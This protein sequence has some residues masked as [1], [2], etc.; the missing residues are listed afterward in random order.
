M[1]TS[2]LG[3]GKQVTVEFKREIFFYFQLNVWWNELLPEQKVVASIVAINIGVFLLWRVVPLQRI[4]LTYF[5][6]SPISGIHSKCFKQ[7][8]V[9]MNCWCLVLRYFEAKSRSC[10]ILWIALI[11]WINWIRLSSF[12]RQTSH[13]SSACL[14]VYQPVCL[15]LCL[16]VKNALMIIFWCYELKQGSLFICLS[17]CLFVCTLLVSVN[18]CNRHELAL[19]LSRRNKEQSS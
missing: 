17:D 14:S 11:W 16:S 15:S 13:L 1:I 19:V 6:S 12:C 9:V 5:T 10:F 18:E 8:T 2:C 3:F 4:M 7:S